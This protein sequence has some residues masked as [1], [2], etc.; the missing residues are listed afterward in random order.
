MGHD[1]TFGLE[2]PSSKAQTDFDCAPRQVI[3]KHERVPDPIEHEATHDLL[4]DFTGF[5]A[6]A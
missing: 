6:T 2:V 3:P 1:T 4:R 5:T